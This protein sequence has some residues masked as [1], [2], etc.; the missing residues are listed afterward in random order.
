[1]IVNYNTL[2]QVEPFHILLLAG[3]DLYE[4]TAPI[5]SRTKLKTRLVS[6]LQHDLIL[7]AESR[8]TERVSWSRLISL[9]Q[10]VFPRQLALLH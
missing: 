5:C 1:M 2:N 10:V 7:M 9:F 3:F 6:W 4:G 8:D